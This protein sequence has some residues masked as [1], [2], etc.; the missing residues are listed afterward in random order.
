MNKKAG[1][2]FSYVF[3]GLMFSLV[4]VGFYIIPNQSGGFWSTYQY[5]PPSNSLSDLD[6]SSEYDDNIV[7]VACDVN[8][9]GSCP[10]SDQGNKFK[11]AS[12]FI[13]S[14]VQGGYSG[15][16]TFS[17]SFGITSELVSEAGDTL[18]IPP[19]IVGIFVTAILALITITTVLIIFNRSDSV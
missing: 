18:E 19:L 9:D 3:A 12:E 16:I 17:K 11:Q 4:I 8:S 5:T 10:N 15:I 14:M 7:D 13:G 6:K 1:V 2:W